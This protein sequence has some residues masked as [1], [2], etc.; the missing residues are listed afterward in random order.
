[1]RK[2]YNSS[3]ICSNFPFFYAFSATPTNSSVSLSFATKAKVYHLAPLSFSTFSPSSLPFST[4]FPPL[5]FPSTPPSHSHITKLTV[6]LSNSPSQPHHQTKTLKTKP[7]QTTT[8]KRKFT[9]KQKQTMTKMRTSDTSLMAMLTHDLLSLTCFLTSHPIHFAYL[10]FFSPYLFSLFSFLSPL[11]ISTL[12]SLLAVV[13][14][15]PYHT[16]TS[17]LPFEFE[18][19]GKTCGSALNVLC[20]VPGPRK[21]NTIGMLEELDE[22]VLSPI[23]HA[24]ADV[25]VSR[26]EF[27]GIMGELCNSSSTI[28]CEVQ[29]KN[30][31]ALLIKG[32]TGTGENMSGDENL[33]SSVQSLNS[34]FYNSCGFVCELDAEIQNVLL[35]ES[36]CEEKAGYTVYLENHNQIS[37]N[38]VNNRISS[39]E[40]E[41]IFLDENSVSREIDYEERNNANLENYKS[42]DSLVGTDMSNGEFDDYKSCASD[43][44]GKEGESNENYPKYVNLENSMQTI[45]SNVSNGEEK[46][47]PKSIRESLICGRT[48]ERLT[49]SF[50]TNHWEHARTPSQGFQREGSLKVVDREWKRTLACKLYEDRITTKLREERK[51]PV[52][53]KEGEGEEEEMDLIWEAIEVNSNKNDGNKRNTKNKGKKEEEREEDSVDEEGEEDD[54]PV[55]QLCCLQAFRVSTRK[56]NL[57]VGRPNLIKLSKVLKKMSVFHVGRNNSKLSDQKK[58]GVIKG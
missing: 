37:N 2:G 42:K 17:H 54:G 53:V 43:V 6:S 19:L 12:L 24:L 31:E 58:T 39:L 35:A 30:Q 40:V 20:T 16:N 1:M 45:T 55:R 28:V 13:T 48:E 3:Q 34:K 41:H 47:E 33:E 46:L 18:F 22:M 21:E 49:K 5:F 4:T 32:G 51:V 7:D 44:E 10:L 27:E 23:V 14:I 50:S 29:N 57:G 56:M 26:I 36:N 9:P 25:E 11:L 15:S 8:R 38:P 52:L